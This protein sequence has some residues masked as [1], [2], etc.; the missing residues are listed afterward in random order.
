MTKI[1]PNRWPNL[2]VV[3]AAKAGTTS[4]YHYLNQHP[5]IYMSPIKEPHF[6]SNIR[7]QARYMALS[8]CVNIQDPQAYLDLFKSRQPHA[9]VGE[10]SPS[11]LWEAQAPERIQQVSPGAKIIVMLREPTRRAYSHY[12]NEVRAGLEKRPFL[13]A[14]QADLASQ[15]VGWGVSPLY[16]ALGQYSEQVQR[17]LDRFDAVQVV[18]FEEFIKDVE[19]HLREI[20][21]FLA[22]DASYANRIDPAVQNGYAIA[23]H[24]LGKFLIGTPWVRNLARQVLAQRWRSQLKWLVLK[25]SPKPPMDEQAR[26][27]LQ[28]IYRSEFETLPQMLGR[29]LPWQAS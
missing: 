7:P 2:F 21:E 18:F 17:Y 23:P 20:F 22:V 28:E 24:P 13:Q 1:W 25:S 14:I 12:L 15:S 10:A 6:F 11:Y 3:G 4:L 26:A 8:G 19:G 5:E 16:V 27:L 9:V 29:A